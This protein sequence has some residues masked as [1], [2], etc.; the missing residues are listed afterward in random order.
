VGTQQHRQNQ[1]MIAPFSGGYF[2]PGMG[3]IV[4]IGGSLVAVPPNPRI[5]ELQLAPMHHQIR[6]LK[7]SKI[8]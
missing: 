1:M 3:A 4:P 5:C 8:G 7:I 2:R 6:S